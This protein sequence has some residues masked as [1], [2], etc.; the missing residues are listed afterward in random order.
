MDIEQTFF[1][2]MED[3]INDEKKFFVLII[4]DISDNKRRKKMVKL[5]ESYGVRVQKSCFEAILRPKKYEKLLSSIK[6]IPNN[7]DSVRVYK[8]QGKSSVETFG[9]PFALEEEEVLIF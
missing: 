4:Y 2:I 9:I 6:K 5:L 1:D 3:S 7:T 8:I